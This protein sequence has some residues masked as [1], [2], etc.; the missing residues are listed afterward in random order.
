MQTTFSPAGT[1]GGV[2]AGAVP[3]VGVQPHR[4]WEHAWLALQEPQV[5]Q[6]DGDAP[7]VRVPQSLGRPLCTHCLVDSLHDSV[8]LHTRPSSGQG[9]PDDLQ[10]RFP[11]SQDSTPLQKMPS[12]EQGLPACCEHVPPLQVSA[13]LQ[14]RPSSQATLSL[15][16]HE[17]ALVLGWRNPCTSPRTWMPCRWPRWRASWR[18]RILL[19]VR[20]PS[21]ASRS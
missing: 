2:S 3:T 13:P 9:V 17:E 7:H 19:R 1:G 11:S 16:L 6:P 8:P 12:S 15:L 5:K 14:Y 18:A 10:R 20:S 21:P 4:P